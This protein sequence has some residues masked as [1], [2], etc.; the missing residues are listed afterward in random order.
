MAKCMLCGK[1]P[2]TGNNVP[3]S[4]HKTKRQIQ[5]NIQSV[6]GV[7]VCTRCIRTL[8]RGAVLLAA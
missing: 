6:D 1:G 5:P 3:K 2:V 7:R 4:Q 8:K